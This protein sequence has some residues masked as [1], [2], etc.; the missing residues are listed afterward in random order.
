MNVILLGL[1]GAGKG[2]QA[3]TIVRETGL[4]HVTTGE[5]FRENIRNGTELGEKARPYYES[6]QLVPDEITIGMIIDRL[7]QPDAARGC[8]FDG[9]PRTLEQARALDEALAQR[10][11]SIDSVL[12][13]K[14]PESNLVDRL[15]GRWTCRNCGAVYHERNSP[16]KQAGVCDR[17]GGELY[18]RDD[19]KQEV[20]AKRLEVNAKQLQQ[21]AA[22]YRKKGKLTDIN[23][24]QEIAAVGR[25]LL[26]AL[27][28]AGRARVANHPQD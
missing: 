20:V 12:Y 25:D 15:A 13:I 17:C 22:Y 5:L 2:T 1:P 9:F 14:V 11:E 18:Q 10:G 23:G 26:A 3:Q 19:D 24:Q 8:L 7:Q 28:T 4:T 6:G 21:L 16:P 27:K